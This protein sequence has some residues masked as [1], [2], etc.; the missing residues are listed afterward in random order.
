M[1]QPPEIPGPAPGIFGSRFRDSL[2]EEGARGALIAFGSSIVVLGLVVV[3]VLNSEAWP[4]VQNQ[5]FNPFHFRESFPLVLRGFWQDIWMF[6]VAEVAILFLAL[7]IAVIRALR[8]PAFFPLRALAITFIDIIRGIPM[9]LLILLMGFGIPALQLPGVTNNALFWGLTA[10]VLGYAAY[11]A[12]VY[13]A[14]IESVPESQRMSARSLGLTQMQTLRHVNVP[15][16]IRNVIPALL[17]GFV[18]LQKAY[19]P[20]WTSTTYTL[21]LLRHLGIDPEDDRVRRAVGLVHDLVSLGEQPFFSYRGETCIT[22]MAL[23]LGAYFQV[24]RDATDRVAEWIINEQRDEGGWNCKAVRGSRRASF[25]TTISVLEGLAEYERMLQGEPDVAAVRSA[26]EEYL[27]ER[28][29][30]WRLST[31]DEINP[32]WK[33]LSFPPR[34]HYDILRGLDHLRDAGADADPRC[35]QV[36][37]IL[38]SKRDKDGRWPL[39]NPH[40]GKVHFPLETTGAASR[41]NTLRALRVL[42]WYRGQTR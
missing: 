24:D 27:L 39:Q 9:I 35:E 30:L 31:S 1:I 22:G 13:R 12:E 11:T 25:H 41:W 3:V 40:R 36:I 19:N 10:I 28:R 38:Q 26:G 2:R 16:A 37:E 8:G 7:V 6:L 14:G 21:L 4:A 42:R 18:S 29:M 33:L 32:K 15:Q 23:A 17:N 34:W 20:K 5:F